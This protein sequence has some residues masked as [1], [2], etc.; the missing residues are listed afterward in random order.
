MNTMQKLYP[1]KFLDAY[2]RDDSQFFFGRNE[3]I[4]QLYNMVFQSDLMLVYGASGTGKTSLI[5]CGLASRFQSHEWLSLF[6]RRGNDINQTFEKVLID[7]GGAI[8]L[9]EKNLDWLD[10]DWASEAEISAV[11]LSPLAKRLKAI[12]LKNFKPIY[13]IFDQF[14]ELYILG[15]K[16]EQLVFFQTVKELLQLDQPVKMIISIREE[17]LGYLYEF[18]RKVPELLRKKLRVE[19][20]TFDKVKSVIEGVGSLPQSIVSIKKGEEAGFSEKVFQK[21]KGDEN[22]I[23]IDLPYLQVFLDKLYM[24]TTGDENRQT[25]AIFSPDLLDNLGN[26]GD[27]LRNFLDEQVMLAAKE[28]NL[29]PDFIWHIL[30]PFVTLEGTKEPLSLQ[31]V[32]DRLPHVS[33]DIISQIIQVFENKR[34]LRYS[35]REQMYEI[36][37][38]S[39][40]RQVN[41]RRSDEEIALLEVQRLIK[42]QS[43]LKEDARE[44]FSAKQLA[45]IEPFL[46][47]LQL[48]VSEIDL[49]DQS[50]EACERERKEE[51]LQLQKERKRQRTIIATVSIAAVI[52]IVFAIFGFVMWQKSEIQKAFA[53]RQE[54]IALLK[55]NEASETLEKLKSSEYMRI[56]SEAMQ[57]AGS[58]LFDDAIERIKEAYRWSS[59]S[60]LINDKIVDFKKMAN[61]ADSF[62]D[63]VIQAQEFEKTE[64]TWL[65]AKQKY[66]QA[67]T[68]GTDK[69]KIN[70]KLN[71]LNDRIASRINYYNDQIST[72]KNYPEIVKQNQEK[73]N[74][75]ISK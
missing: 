44:L 50:R 71:A 67:L 70:M 20:M 3:E 69:E 19:P 54:K 17:Y 5:Q 7:N 13:L 46:N 38:D 22:R 65:K 11:N 48:T 4:E 41:A 73:L 28:F 75:L 64:S 32:F 15:S 33:S 61:E 34:I 26:I 18:E 23:S 66:N 21:I 68:Y 10:Q 16:E 74:C 60:V 14:E 24:D 27:V 36:A 56:T 8:D 59:D 47:Q 57:M 25:E 12:Y 39:L 6:I 49:I 37:H 40:A 31:D 35:E 55:G 62:L 53:E 9:S 52:S 29:K 63:I 1:F 43:T 51:L 45:F 72:F 30:S 42:S 58:G 2:T